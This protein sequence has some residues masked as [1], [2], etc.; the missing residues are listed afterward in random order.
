MIAAESELQ[1]AVCQIIISHGFVRDEDIKSHIIKIMG[2][3]NVLHDG[4][5]GLFQ[6]INQNLRKLSFEIKSVVLKDTN[7]THSTF[8][9]FVNTLDDNISKSFGSSFTVSEVKFFEK[10]CVEILEKKCLNTNDIVTLKE[11]H[12]VVNH[13]Q[14][15]DKLLSQG[16]LRKNESNYWE[17]GV[18]SY[19]ELRTHFES[20]LADGQEN[21]SMPLPQIIIY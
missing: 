11:N 6:R 16:W 7:G 21:F 9:G 2:N 13:D 3:D 14:F 5:G 19:L 18:K 4:I 17:L 10:I 15:L 20:I 12:Q 8:H 1:K